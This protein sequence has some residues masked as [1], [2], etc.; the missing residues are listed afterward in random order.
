[1]ESDVSIGQFSHHLMEYGFAL[2]IFVGIQ[3]K[4]RSNLT[5]IGIARIKRVRLPW[6][7][8]GENRVVL[9]H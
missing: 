3:H 4:S 6:D 2:G 5:R 8:G 1:M 9:I 7:V